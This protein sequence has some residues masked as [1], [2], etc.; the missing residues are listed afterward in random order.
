MSEM[1]DAE[2]ERRLRNTKRQTIPWQGEFEWIE[3]AMR[4]V[5]VTN[6]ALKRLDGTWTAVRR[7]YTVFEGPRVEDELPLTMLRAG[8]EWMRAH[9]PDKALF[10]R[11]CWEVPGDL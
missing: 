10:F 3:G 6:S 5:F 11:K 4:L 7:T 9:H 2:I 8:F 1:T